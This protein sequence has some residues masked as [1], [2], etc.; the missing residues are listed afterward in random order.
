[1]QSHGELGTTLLELEDIFRA[2]A[3]VDVPSTVLWLEEEVPPPLFSRIRALF[4]I[5]HMLVRPIIGHVWATT[6][7]WITVMG[8]CLTATEDV[9]RPGTLP[10]LASTRA[11]SLLQVADRVC[12]RTKA[13]F[14]GCRQATMASYRIAERLTLR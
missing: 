8:D 1:V 12:E 14:T 2:A 7:G 6:Q 11:S 10:V 13:I 4:A 5:P 9:N 3:G